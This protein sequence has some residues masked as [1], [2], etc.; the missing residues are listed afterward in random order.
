MMIFTVLLSLLL[1]FFCPLTAKAAGGIE[2]STA[3]PGIT[4]KAGE[5]VSVNL[6]L[7]NTSGSA[8]DAALSPLSMPE[9]WEGYFAAAG[10]K[11]ISKVRCTQWR[12]GKRRT[13]QMTIPKDAA[14]GT[15]QVP[16]RI[17]QTAGFL[18]Q[19]PWTLPSVKMNMDSSF[20]TEYPSQEDHPERHLHLT[21]LL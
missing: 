17:Q 14:E 9:G 15:Y 12:N 19:Q 13:F 8:F 2:L 18:I 1:T 21:R 11:Q 10:G 4:V 20:T 5:A 6:D 16:L 3:Y 7:E